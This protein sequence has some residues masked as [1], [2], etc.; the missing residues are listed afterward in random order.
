MFCEKGIMV[1]THVNKDVFTGICRVKEY[2]RR[3][4]G[5]G[6]IYIFDNCKNMIEEFMGYSWADGDTPVKKEDHA[7]DELRYF[8][9]SKPKPAEKEVEASPLKMD[10]MRRIRRLKRSGG[11]G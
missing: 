11:K 8:V 3:D 7:M 10:K 9:M 4:N 1:N 6:N 2:L 5:T